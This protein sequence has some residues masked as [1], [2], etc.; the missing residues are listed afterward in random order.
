[1]FNFRSI[2]PYFAV[3]NR[4][5]TRTYNRESRTENPCVGGSGLRANEIR[6]LRIGAFDF[7]NLTVS[8]EAGYSKH[9]QKDTLPLKSDLAAELKEFFKGKMPSVKAFGGTYKRLTKKTAPMI[10]ADL[11][12]TGIAYIDDNGKVF[13]FHS[14]RH[15]FIT[16]LRSAPSRVAQSLAR[17]KSS[18]MTDRYT[19]IRVHDERAALETLPDLSLPSK[20]Q[21]AKKTGTDDKPVNAVGDFL[22]DSCFQGAKVRSNAQASGKKSVLSIQ[23]TPLCVNN[24]GTGRTENPC[25]GGSRTNTAA[26][27]NA[28]AQVANLLTSKVSSLVFGKF[29]LDRK[30]CFLY[31]YLF[32]FV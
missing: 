26:C 1:M 30:S 32:L 12:A 22:L 19:H 23:K 11:E 15:T 20:E 2:S 10:K 24:K 7:D 27:P 4:L 3:I 25:V 18:A 5:P 6:T 8:V 31:I 21:Q 28:S 29:F 14:V 9:R 16:N 13:D 17:H